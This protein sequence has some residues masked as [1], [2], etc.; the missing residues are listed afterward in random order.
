[1]QQLI[2]LC[3][4]SQNDCRGKA[5]RTLA[6]KSCFLPFLLPSLLRVSGCWWS[7]S[8]AHATGGLKRAIRHLVPSSHSSAHVNPS[9][10]RGRGHGG[11]ETQ[12]SL[13][14][15]DCRGARVQVPA[16]H[17]EVLPSPV[18]CMTSTAPRA[19]T[20]QSLS[21]LVVTMPLC[22]W[23]WNHARRWCCDYNSL[24]NAHEL[25]R[26]TSEL[27]HILLNCLLTV[28][29]LTVDKSNKLVYW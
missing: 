5:P 25:C 22:Y 2:H 19:K 29:L 13:T 6:L 17:S 10:I 24:T 21:W 9:V 16:D 27:C 11:F 20:P 23:T 18:S 1:M 4:T 12:G 26:P 15:N 14:Y 3:L 7:C 8:S 28:H